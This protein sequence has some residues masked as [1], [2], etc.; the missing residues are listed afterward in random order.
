MAKIL[1]L[2]GGS[3]AAIKVPSLLRRLREAGHQV[4]VAATPAALEFVSELSL[5]TAAGQAP[6]SD[7][8]WFSPVGGALH[9]E[10]AHWPDL[11]IVAPASA[12]LMAQAALG[13]AGSLI[14][15]TLL[16][17]RV[18]VLWVP[19]MNPAMWQHPATRL[20]HQTLLGWGQFFLGPEYGSLGT[21]GEGEG[22]G[23][24]AEPVEI[25]A[26]VNS[27]LT[28]K[29]LAG[30]RLLVSA[31]PT[32]EYLD[33]V[34]FISNPSSGRMGYAVAQTG[35]DRGAQV[36]LVSG[37]VSLD[38]P[39]GVELVRVESA[40]ELRQAMLDRAADADAVVMTAAVADYRPE[41]FAS[42]KVP[43]GPET[44]NLKL[45][46]NPDILRELGQLEPRPILVGFA[47]ETEAGLE[48]ALA[49]ARE[50]R[51]DFICLNFPTQE[52]T[53]FGGDYNQVTLVFPEGQVQELPRMSKLAVASVILDNIQRIWLASSPP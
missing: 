49:K 18:P 53:P 41:T 21:V 6:A 15:A 1:V 43:K 7:Q 34:R 14:P 39:T 4:R 36:T 24:M 8:Q 12:E 38:P 47:M 30:L 33:P 23:R 52:A 13:L 28:P 2:V 10:L 44:V 45:I 48:R 46:R 50:K 22:E 37:P 3:V 27:L 9:L 51:L 29:D 42:Q 26:Q 20:H 40:L 32:R 31:G 5:A 17:I 25:V 11:A 35:R 19:A 16:S